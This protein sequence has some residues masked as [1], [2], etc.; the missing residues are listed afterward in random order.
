MTAA[1][2]L[3]DKEN[4][5]SFWLVFNRCPGIGPALI[6]QL[7]SKH[8]KLSDWFSHL[9]P[10]SELMMWLKAKNISSPVFDWDGVEKDLL[11]AE[12]SH[13]HIVTLK[14]EHYPK[15]LAQIASS[16]PVLFV[17][18]QVH[19]LNQ[20]QV[21]MV[22]SRHPTVE[23]KRNAYDIANQLS[24]WG[25]IVTS[26]LALGI[27]AACHAGALSSTSP[28]VAVLG[29][30]LGSIYPIKNRQLGEKIVENGA[31]VSELPT[32]ALPKREHFPRRNRI[33]SGLSLGVAVVE[34][35]EKSGSLITASYALE[36]GREV[37]ALPGSIHNPV[38]KG[39]H[40]LIRQGALCI[41]NASQ[42]LE[43]LA[44]QLTQFRGDASINCKAEVSH[45]P[46][47][48]IQ[49]EIHSHKQDSIDATL[50]AAILD[51]CTPID[52]ILDNTGLTPQEVTTTLLRLELQ[53]VVKSVP[54]G[55]IRLTN[56]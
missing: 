41:E 55:V 33:I 50:I 39:C 14:E 11:W 30:G 38:A 56:R 17:K 35:A 22:G 40:H 53:G 18:G 37:F 32:T 7:L 10:T 19:L 45:K 49:E 15:Q 36:Q 27:D 44:P 47:P 28:T 2:H 20:P 13:C 42:I 1:N 52:T 6:N 34:A 29:N 23:G 21:G 43:V 31:L 4:D 12:Q 54:G 51:T 5:L 8:N 24:S 3:C 25:M 26:G 9:R 16:P 46:N 48:F